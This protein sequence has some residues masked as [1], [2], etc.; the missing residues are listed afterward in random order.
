MSNIKNI[1]RA[2]DDNRQLEASKEIIYRLHTYFIHSSQKLPVCKAHQLA[3]HLKVKH[4]AF[5]NIVTDQ[6][7][8]VSGTWNDRNMH[9]F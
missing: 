1:T 3:I 2:Y 8:T 7:E 9:K 4:E 5:E 6:P